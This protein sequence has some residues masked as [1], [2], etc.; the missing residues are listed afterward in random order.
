[1]AVCCQLVP[2]GC[3]ESSVAVDRQSKMSMISGGVHDV[4]SPVIKKSPLTVSRKIYEF[5]TAPITKFW[6]HT[7]RTHTVT[8]LSVCLSVCPSVCLSVCLSVCMSV[9][10]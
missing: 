8:L 3:S 1:M 4:F 2:G 9:C 6:M 7:V 5:Y 10:L